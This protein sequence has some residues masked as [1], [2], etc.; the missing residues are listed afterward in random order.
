MCRSSAV[1]HRRAVAGSSR[2]DGHGGAGG[3]CWCQ[4]VGGQVGEAAAQVASGG[5]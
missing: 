4:K 1:R 5:G 2:G 3:Q